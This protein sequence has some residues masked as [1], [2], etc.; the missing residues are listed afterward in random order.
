MDFPGRGTRIDFI[1]GVDRKKES[2]E[3]GEGKMQLRGEC[4]GELKSI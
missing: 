2:G 4:G 1:G 3:V